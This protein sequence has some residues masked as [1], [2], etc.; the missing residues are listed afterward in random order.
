M[1]TDIHRLLDEAF[2]GI[3]MSPEAR[4]LKEEVRANLVARVA[5]M[6]A[7]GRPPAAAAQRAI[8]ELGDVGELLER[9]DGASPASAAG[10][11]VAAAERNRV[12]PRPGFVVRVVVASLV[13]AIGLT[14]AALSATEMLTMPLGVTIALVGVAATSVAWIVGDCLAQETTTNRPMP[15]PR[16]GGYFLATLL[17]GY[18]LGLVGLIALGVLPVWGIVFAALGIVAAI[19]L[20]AWLGATQTNRHKAWVRRAHPDLPVNR[21]EEEPET[22][23]RFGIYTAVIWL[24]TFGVIV[25]F[26]FTIGWWWT[27]VAFLGGI[28][29]MMLVLARMMFGPRSGN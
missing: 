12:R 16:A 10:E 15:G 5:E 14:L 9:I 2:T 3:E 11:R 19:I 28:V 7:A 1:N 22:A 17:A 26:V 20:F 29:V 13:A 8:A 18:G 27:P 6:E 23:A 4:D 25:V 24:M 21:F